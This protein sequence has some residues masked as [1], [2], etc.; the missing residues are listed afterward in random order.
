MKYKNFT[1][2]KSMKWNEENEEQLMQLKEKGVSIA[3]IA[4]ML[5]TTQSSVK[6]KYTRLMQRKNADTHHHPTEKIRQIEEVLKSMDKEI[7]VL[8]T[9]AGYGNLTEVY[10]IYAEN[11]LSFDLDKAKCDYVNNLG[12]DNVVC[13]K[14]DSLKEIY[15]SAYCGLKF[16]VIDLDPYGFPSRYFPMVFEL[17]D[18]GFMFIT[19]PKYGC[20]QVNKITQHHVKNYYGFDGGSNDEF[21]GCFINTLRKQLLANY[22]E[23][24]VVDALD[25]QKVYRL[26][27]KIEKKNAYQMCGYEHLTKKNRKEEL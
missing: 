13:R 10:S 27:I 18:D 24:K 4:E 16:N 22:K 17:I 11:V 20:A 21:L 2:V 12:H 8:E 5:G 19:L 1:Q 6:H 23:M 15:L 25:L 3:R 26:A 7:F 14:G 9:H